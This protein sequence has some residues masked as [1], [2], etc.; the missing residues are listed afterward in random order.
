[1]TQQ[2]GTDWCRS[3][4]IRRKR[5]LAAMNMSLAPTNAD[6]WQIKLK[7]HWFAQAHF[8]DGRNLPQND[9]PALG[10][11]QS[12]CA[13]SF[14]LAGAP[15]HTISYLVFSLPLNPPCDSQ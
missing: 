1:M 2:R 11:R 4:L 5:T 14:A 8:R 15:E 12:L 7:R 6:I 9:A 3:N 10:A 13:G